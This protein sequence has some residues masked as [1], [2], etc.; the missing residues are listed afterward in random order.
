MDV[1]TQHSGSTV[2]K[3]STVH[4]NYLIEEKDFLLL[5]SS[6]GKLYPTGRAFNQPKESLF[7]KF[8]E[9]LN[10][11]FARVLRDAKLL[12]DYN[13]PDNDNFKKEDVLI[14]EDR[15]GLRGSD[16]VDLK[17]RKKAIYRK[18]G[19]PNNVKYRQSLGFIQYQLNI[20]GFSVFLHENT[21]TYRTPEE[22]SNINPNEQ[23]HSEN[24]FHSSN[25]RHGE[26]NFKVIANSIE[27][28]ESYSVGSSNLW[29][30][31]FIG[32]QALGSKAN[33]P[34]GRLR[35]FKELILKLK[36]A[37]TVAFTF[38]NYT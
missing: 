38:I 36:P 35:E 10:I 28:V 7:H 8:N 19:H 29:A 33:V 34:Y 31:F 9:A 3:D 21:P 37:H 22:V 15:L 11:S 20:A 13:I 25:T 6:F 12:L 5:L 24:V 17:D 27:E 32:G 23:Q 1:N 30:T 14:W 4:K 18:M 2:H 26:D 16:L